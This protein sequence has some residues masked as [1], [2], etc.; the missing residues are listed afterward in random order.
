MPRRKKSRRGA[1]KRTLPP[2]GREIFRTRLRPAT[3]AWLRALGQGWA[4]RGIEFLEKN[5]QTQEE[6]P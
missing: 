2:D 3:V 4:N 5:H 6:R 1:P